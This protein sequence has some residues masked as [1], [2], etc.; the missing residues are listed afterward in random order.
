MT[1]QNQF[2]PGETA[3]AHQRAALSLRYVKA[4]LRPWKPVT[5]S[6]SCT[7]PRVCWNSAAWGT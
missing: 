2:D 4:P 7:P 6:A 3:K 1:T 5:R